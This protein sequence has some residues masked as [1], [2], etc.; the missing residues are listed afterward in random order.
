MP[1]SEILFIVALAAINLA[2]GMGLA[3]VIS[4]RLGEIAGVARTPARYAAIVMGVYF[5]ECVAFAA[6]MA[7][8]VFSVG[9]AVLWGI[10]F[11]LWLRAGRPASGIVRTLVLFGVYTSL[12]TV[13]FGLLLLL[14]KWLDGADVMSTVDGAALG[15]LGFVPWPMSTILGFCL[16]L[17]AGT[18]IIKTGVTVGLATA[19]AGLNGKQGAAQLEQ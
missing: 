12:P 3:L 1:T 5:L 4:R 10:V 6:G 9:L 2:A 19:V 15:I 8:Q 16:V 11:G 14:A 7:T 17:A 13:S 18:L